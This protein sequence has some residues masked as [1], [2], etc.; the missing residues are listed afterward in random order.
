[1]PSRSDEPSSIAFLTWRD[2]R[3]PDGGG[4]EVYVESVARELVARGHRV[5][6]RCARHRGSAAREVV[7]GVEIVRSGGRLTVYAKSLLWAMTAGR[8]TDVVV[9]VINGLPFMARLARRRGLV[10]LVHHVHREQWH[11]IYPGWRGRLGWWIESRLT[12]R[13]Y[14]D[15][16][17]LTVSES[18]RRDLVALGID[19]ALIH[20]A[21]NGLDPRPVVEADA[22][23][24]RLSVLSRLVPH[25]QVD[26]AFRVV[27]ALRDRFPDIELDVIGDGWWRDE[28]VAAARA[29]GVEDR[30]LFHGRVSADRRDELLASSV[31]M[32]LP[33]VKEGW[34]LAVVEAAAQG[35]PTIAYRSAGG[36]TESVVDGE[37]GLLVDSVDEMVEATAT[38]LSDTGRRAQLSARALQRAGRFTW[39]ATTDEVERVIAQVRDQSP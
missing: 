6:V 37:T 18:S 25:K 19:P 13:V 11:I 20:V 29:E 24:A 38:L 34:G 14:R 12:P 9:D 7:D 17:H 4:S 3:H 32:L 10:A 2:Q 33:S 39:T 30:V 8:R 27:R 5:Q 22:S 1:M 15:V 36:V 26:H 16:V 23:G 31:A 28:L 35:T 21:H